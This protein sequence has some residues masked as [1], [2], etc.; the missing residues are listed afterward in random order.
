MS[1]P[2]ML[3]QRTPSLSEENN[4]ATLE[5]WKGQILYHVVV[6]VA[7]GFIFILFV[8]RFFFGPPP[9]NELVRLFL[10]VFLQLK[11]FWTCCCRRNF[12]GLFSRKSQLCRLRT[13][14]SIV[15]RLQ[16]VI[17]NVD[18]PI[19]PKELLREWMF[20][21][22]SCTLAIVS[23]TR[24]TWICHS[25]STRRPVSGFFQIVENR[26]LKEKS[27][28][29]YVCLICRHF[30]IPESNAMFVRHLNDL[31]TKNFEVTCHALLFFFFSKEFGMFCK[32]K[33]K[34]CS[35]FYLL[36]QK[37]KPFQF[38]FGVYSTGL[39]QSLLEMCSVPG[40]Q[41]SN[42]MVPMSKFSAWVG[43]VIL[44]LFRFI[45]VGD[46]DERSLQRTCIN[47][48][49]NKWFR[50]NGFLICDT[51]NPAY[52]QRLALL[53]NRQN[54]RHC[55]LSWPLTKPE[56]NSAKF[57]GK[58]K[59]KGENT[60]NEKVTWKSAFAPGVSAC[61]DDTTYHKAW[62]RKTNITWTAMTLAAYLLVSHA[63]I[64][65][66]WCA[67]MSAI[68]DDQVWENGTSRRNFI[69]FYLER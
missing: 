65:P 6:P 12:C 15:W 26:C 47:S 16:C 35:G 66:L 20:H 21:M 11:I 64:F 52:R 23:V 36:D 18:C 13:V 54:R 46:N 49:C 68:C 37:K 58:K 14:R 42:F 63:S 55:S 34:Y 9:F 44:A 19:F 30:Y 32:I 27:T 62:R 48:L 7:T 53:L 61:W 4:V 59:K 31:C 69:W 39:K 24:T 50:T 33:L 2:S 29:T 10:M 57:E 56:E 22:R 17:T 51:T 45:W 38:E 43:P 28:C 5:Y 1:R 67:K 40:E 41:I 25:N 3:D 8:F 60:A